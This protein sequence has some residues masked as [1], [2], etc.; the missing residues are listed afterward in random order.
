MP[1]LSSRPRRRADLAVTGQ[2]YSVTTEGG[3]TTSTTK[4]T[5][6]ASSSAFTGGQGKA[7]STR[8]NRMGI[9]NLIV[10]SFSTFS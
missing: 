5:L 9:T 3:E 6:V 10:F 1:R 7:A 2:A 4:S 8:H